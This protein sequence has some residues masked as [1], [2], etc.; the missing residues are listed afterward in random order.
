MLLYFCSP[1]FSTTANTTQWRLAA[2][3]SAARARGCG[4]ARTCARPRST[5]PIIIPPVDT[6]RRLFES[7]WRTSSFRKKIL[8]AANN[9]GNFPGAACSGAAS[10]CA[11]R[12]ARSTRRTVYARALLCCVVSLCAEIFR[13]VDEAEGHCRQL[14]PSASLLLR[15]YSWCV[16]QPPVFRLRTF[17]SVR[18][19]C[20]CAFPRRA[21]AR[22]GGGRGVF[23]APLRRRA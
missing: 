13:R 21:S 23:L 6:A 9:I 4:A 14:L 16:S 5:A 20:F 11:P 2:P 1:Y 18:R 3:L 8:A 17:I 10:T 22:Q 19:S 7:E 15:R 12:T